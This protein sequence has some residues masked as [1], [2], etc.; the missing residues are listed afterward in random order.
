MVGQVGEARVRAAAGVDLVGNAEVVE[1]LHR[2]PKAGQR[3]AIFL[4][5]C[6]TNPFETERDTT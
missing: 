4:K 2:P 5:R 1:E 6:G 3:D